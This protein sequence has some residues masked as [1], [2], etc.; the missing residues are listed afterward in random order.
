MNIMIR[1]ALAADV[2]AM[3][4]LVKELAEYEKSLHKVSNTESQMLKD[5]FGEHPY[6]GAFVAEDNEEIIGISIYY[7]RY[8]TW[9]GIR[10]YLEDIVV[11]E[12]FRGKGVGKL[13]FE[14]TIQKGKE[15]SC[16]GMMWQVLDWNKS[17]IGFY[18]KYGAKFDEEWVNCHLDF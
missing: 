17:A 7:Y 15:E 13:L 5:G 12:A 4:E 18:E 14:A 2:P 1:E 9:K 6:F 16:T 10:I 8:S 11:K 3:M